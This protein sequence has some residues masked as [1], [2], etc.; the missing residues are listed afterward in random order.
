MAPKKPKISK[1]AAAGTTRHTIP[2]TLETIIKN[3]SATRHSVPM[4]AYKI[5]LLTVQT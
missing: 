2:E 3:G 4:A 1:Q 5:G